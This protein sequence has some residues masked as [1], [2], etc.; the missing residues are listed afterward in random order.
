MKDPRQVIH[1]L[2]VT[3]KGTAQQELN[4]KYFFKVAPGA[5]K[6]EIK[7]AVEQM[8]AVSVAKV[9]TM[10]YEGKRK[11]ERTV[12]YGKRADWKRA[13]VTLREGSKIDLV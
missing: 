13:V 12:R 7:H 9:N 4:N 5:N 11:R 1:E 8:F 2:Q 6:I 10:K 3:E